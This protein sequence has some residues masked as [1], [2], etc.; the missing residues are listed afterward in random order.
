MKRISIILTFILICGTAF[1]ASADNYNA[2]IKSLIISND[3]AVQIQVLQSI[4]TIDGFSGVEQ[5]ELRRT[6]LEIIKNSENT[7]DP[8]RNAGFLIEAVRLF[9]DDLRLSVK[10][11]KAY[12]E[13]GQYHKALDVEAEILTKSGNK[14]NDY[15]LTTA[16][17]AVQ[18]LGL[19][20]VKNYKLAHNDLKRVIKRDPR[21]TGGYFLMGAY[22]I[23]IKNYKA[24]AKYFKKCQDLNPKHKG[25]ADM[26]VM[27]KRE[28]KI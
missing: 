18:A 1:A 7:V 16:A 28:G 10:L 26:L 27:L 22:Y 13:L 2:A 20:M 6:I 24:A 12:A 15:E 9:P 4:K 14:N 11:T 17:H 8:G 21:W 19:M 23:R 25:A 5:E 3:S